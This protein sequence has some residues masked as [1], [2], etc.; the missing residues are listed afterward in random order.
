MS[1][2][3]EYVTCLYDD[4][5]EYFSNLYIGKHKKWNTHTH[6][7]THPSPNIHTSH[8]YQLIHI[9]IHT[10]NMLLLDA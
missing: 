2:I 10:Y 3:T 9:H 4:T 5:C 8:T 1:R 6:T 7:Y